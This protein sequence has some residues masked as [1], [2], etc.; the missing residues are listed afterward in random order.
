MIKY[1]WFVFVIVFVIVDES[2]SEEEQ[3]R[4]S[5]EKK[6]VKRINLPQLTIFLPVS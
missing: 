4:E 2:T 5:L 1:I 3:L 6:W